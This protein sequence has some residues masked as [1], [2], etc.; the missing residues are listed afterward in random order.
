LTIPKSIE[1]F[2]SATGFSYNVKKAQGKLL[3]V[4][5]KVNMEKALFKL[6]TDKNSKF[7]NLNLG[8]SL[9]DSFTSSYIDEYEKSGY[10][11]LI[12][13]GE[14]ADFHKDL[15]EK[16]EKYPEIISSGLINIANR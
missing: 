1:W 10:N 16:R 7:D 13:Y 9:V 6:F 5:V 3:T 14:N 15:I 4:A 8:K 2:S 11:N 12:V